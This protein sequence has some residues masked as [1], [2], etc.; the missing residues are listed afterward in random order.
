MLYLLELVFG[1]EERNFVEVREHKKRVKNVIVVV[2][3]RVFVGQRS[4]FL[5]RDHV[6]D[7]KLLLLQISVSKI[8]FVK[9]EALSITA[10]TLCQFMM[11]LVVV[12]SKDFNAL[13]CFVLN[14]HKVSGNTPILNQSKAVRPL[15][16]LSFSE[17][18]RAYFSH[19][20]FLL[21]P[22]RRCERVIIN[23]LS[24]LTY[25]FSFKIPLILVDLL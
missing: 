6:Y 7:L 21:I 12:Y 4:H 14:H 20:V 11:Q 24:S 22:Y 13:F 9:T 23:A 10:Q 8:L 1:I 17:F 15:S 16:T 2:I 18:K 5:F 25:Q 3:P 19:F